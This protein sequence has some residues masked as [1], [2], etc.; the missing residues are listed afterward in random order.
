MK[1]MLDQ[2]VN[3]KTP[4]PEKATVEKSKIYGQCLRYLSK[5][6]SDATN[7][8]VLLDIA[9]YIESSASTAQSHT[10]RMQQQI[11]TQD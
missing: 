5:L 2:M 7:Q 9:S 11:S 8:Q 3:Q 6:E 1:Q 4:A 10:S